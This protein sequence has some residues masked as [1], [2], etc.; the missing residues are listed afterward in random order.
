[1]PDQAT[2][3]AEKAALHELLAHAA[4]DDIR[5][6]PERFGLT[7]TRRSARRVRVMLRLRDGVSGQPFNM[8]EALAIEANAEVGGHQGCQLRLGEDD[9]AAVIGA[10][11]LAGIEADPTLLPQ[12]RAALAGVEAARARKAAQERAAVRATE[13]NFEGGEVE[14]YDANDY[15]TDR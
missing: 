9:E 5:D 2:D 14:A 15:S 13:I 11:L 7:A 12:V 10:T 4:A 3:L 1:M 8:T 6:L